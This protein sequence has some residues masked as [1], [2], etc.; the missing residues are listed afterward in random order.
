MFDF[1]LNNTPF[2]GIAIGISTFLIIG[3]FHPLVVKG[4]YYLG[5]RVWWLFLILGLVA[6]V[7]SFCVKTVFAAAILSII[8]FSSFWG[9]LEVF[10]QRR[11]VEK[12][13]F[14]ENPKRKNKSASTD[15]ESS[16]IKS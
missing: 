10:S 8:S 7:A 1:V 5:V 9:I 16:D 2:T 11:R 3:L 14:P 12:G 15:K 6:V 4:E 13:W